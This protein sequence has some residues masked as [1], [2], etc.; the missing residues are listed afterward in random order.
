M[1]NPLAIINGEVASITT[2]IN[3]PFKSEMIES[4]WMRSY[5]SRISG[6]TYNG[7]VEFRNGNTKGEQTFQATTF[8]DLI[9]QIN[10]F[11]EELGK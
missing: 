2:D 4:I 1:S 3:D 7:E 10:L 6:W 5:K 8:N 9:A 11:I